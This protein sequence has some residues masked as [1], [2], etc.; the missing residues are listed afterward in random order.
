MWNVWH[1]GWWWKERKKWG[2]SAIPGRGLIPALSHG[3][4]TSPGAAGDMLPSLDVAVTVLYK[5]TVMGKVETILLLAL[6][7][8]SPEEGPASFS[9]PLLF[10]ERHRSRPTSATSCNS[11]LQSPHWFSSGLPAQYMCVLFVVLRL[12]LPSRPKRSFI[13]IDLKA[14]SIAQSERRSTS[15]MAGAHWEGVWWL[16]QLGAQTYQPSL[17]LRNKTFQYPGRLCSFQQGS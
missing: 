16:R 15:N 2:V 5:S 9:I 11:H 12:L 7:K 14:V 1:R 4:A 10:N 6:E 17:P 8:Y 3:R 13:A